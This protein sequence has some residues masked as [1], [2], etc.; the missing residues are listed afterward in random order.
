MSEVRL[1]RIISFIVGVLGA[2]LAVYWYD[3]RLV[4]I[5]FILQWSENIYNI[6]QFASADKLSRLAKALLGL[7]K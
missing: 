5:L 6:A 1:M 3:W 2:S 7:Y 4:L